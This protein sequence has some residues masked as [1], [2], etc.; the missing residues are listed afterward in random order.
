[1]MYEKG[2]YIVY[3]I[4][5][6]CEIVDIT[7]MERP[8]SPEGRLYYV[9]RPCCQKNSKIVAPV[10]S[11][12]TVTRPVMSRDEALE[13]IDGMENVPELSVTNDKL[14][15]ERYK[16][17]LKTCDCHVWISM[18]KAL[19]QRR[20][21]RLAR[22]K[23]LTDLD[24]RYFRTAEENLYSEL[25]MALGIAREDMAEYIKERVEA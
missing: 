8:G 22:G 25:S 2:Q 3:G 5:G 4:R 24:E 7:T 16:E 10:D 1:M 20:R 13:L 9:L 6:V 23:R 17:A 12:L 11:T 14:R 15:E 19:Y 21:E 18:L